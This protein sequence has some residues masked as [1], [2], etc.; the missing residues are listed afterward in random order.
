[1]V[2]DFTSF[3]ERVLQWAVNVSA[4]VPGHDEYGC[5]EWN[6]H[7]R[8]QHFSDMVTTCSIL[9]IVS[10]FAGTSFIP[11]HVVSSLLH[12]LLGVELGMAVVVAL[13][14]L[15]VKHIIPWEFSR[16]M[17]RHM[18]SHF[19]LASLVAGMLSA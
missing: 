12:L 17:R 15:S 1:M 6:R 19:L 9:G 18:V 13:V 11:Y 16:W 3:S 8:L 14:A 7:G 10:V 2:H 4:S 5:N